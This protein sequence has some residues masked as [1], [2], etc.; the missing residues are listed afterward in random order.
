MNPLDTT[1]RVHYPASEKKLMLVWYTHN[2][3]THIILAKTQDGLEK[4]FTS[5]SKKFSE[6]PEVQSVSLIQTGRP[7]DELLLRIRQRR[8]SR[9]LDEFKSWIFC[10]VY[11][12]VTYHNLPA[13]FFIGSC[14][15]ENGCDE[16]DGYKFSLQGLSWGE[17]FKRG[18][19]T[20]P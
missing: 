15:C 7:S 19:D 8:E 20:W 4:T 2:E 3:G 6:L 14:S 11:T 1:P 16:C 13:P 9:I 18:A 17:A 12:A 10:A 5:V